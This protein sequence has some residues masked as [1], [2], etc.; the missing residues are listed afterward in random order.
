VTTGPAYRGA[1]DWSDR[2]LTWAESDDSGERLMVTAADTSG[3][4]AIVTL[5]PGVKLTNPRWL[6]AS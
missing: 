2:G 3:P 4:R 6:K 5:Q 1:P